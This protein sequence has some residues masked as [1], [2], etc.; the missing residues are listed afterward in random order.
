VIIGMRT[1][2]SSSVGRAASI[3][4]AAASEAEIVIFAVPYLACAEL[5]PPLADALDGK[6]VVDATNP[7]NPDWSPVTIASGT[8][9]A[10]EIAAFLPKSSVIKAFNTIFADIMVPERQTRSSGIATAFVAGD[11]L[12]AKLA[13]MDF[14][15]TIGFAPLDVGALS[16]A[17]YLEG[18]AH[19][20]I[21]IAIGQ[22]GGTNAAFIYDQVSPATDAN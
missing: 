8:S 17:L 14:A 18:M 1:P 16:K 11:D 19:L 7:L 13:V 4:E 10:E 12:A 2:Q 9:G 22:K 5:L 15:K 20:N 3:A 6:I 21:G